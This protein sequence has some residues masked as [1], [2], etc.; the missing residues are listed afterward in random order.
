[1]LAQ[2]DVGGRGWLTRVDLA[3]L[4]RGKDNPSAKE[5]CTGSLPV[6]EKASWVLHGTFG[7]QPVDM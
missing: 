6:A 7:G 2:P 1:V 3:A 4:A 5:G